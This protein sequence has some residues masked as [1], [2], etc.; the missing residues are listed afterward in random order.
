MLF[1]YN[2]LRL[3]GFGVLGVWSRNPSGLQD[4]IALTS[5]SFKSLQFQGFRASGV[6]SIRVLRL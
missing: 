5:S 4:R 3:Y 2:V 6:Y 1:V